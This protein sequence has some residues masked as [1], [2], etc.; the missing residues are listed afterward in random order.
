MFAEF[1][2]HVL[3]NDYSVS[4]VGAIYN[5]NLFDWTHRIDNLWKLND[6][7]C[8]VVAII[9]H[10]ARLFCWINSIDLIN[11]RL[12]NQITRL[13]P[14][15]LMV[16]LRIAIYLTIIN[17]KP[18]YNSLNPWFDANKAHLWSN[19]KKIKVIIVLVHQ[20]IYCILPIIIIVALL[21]C[22]IH[23]HNA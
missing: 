11:I 22:I 20:R 12:N 2:V 16:L 7:C 21:E 15:K 14:I 17:L 1:V 6:L 5:L 19:A 9:R 13:F 23:N 4:K 3:S 18:R 10:I 8:N